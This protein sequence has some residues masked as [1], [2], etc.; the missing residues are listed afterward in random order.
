MLLN[1]TTA[2]DPRGI[3]KAD[4]AIIGISRTSKTPLCMYLANKQVKAV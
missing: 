1:M 3:L 4:I 2:G